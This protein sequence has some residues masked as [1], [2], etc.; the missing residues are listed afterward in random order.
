MAQE[1]KHTMK[2]STSLRRRA[3]EALATKDAHERYVD[4]LVDKGQT[5]VCV[6]TLHV[7]IWRENVFLR[8][9]LFARKRLLYSVK[10]TLVF[11]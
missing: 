4:Q 10:I 9:K 7:K 2:K 3:I 6:T 11:V 8:Q 1:K 5:E